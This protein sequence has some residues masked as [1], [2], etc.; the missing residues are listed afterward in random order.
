[1]SHIASEDHGLSQS[2]KMWYKP[3][4]SPQLAL[5]RMS[6]RTTQAWRHHRAPWYLRK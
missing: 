2:G 3:Y 6:S 4:H 5:L 1:M